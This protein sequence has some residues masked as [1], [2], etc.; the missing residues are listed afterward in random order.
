MIAHVILCNACRLQPRFAFRQELSSS[1]KLSI[2]LRYFQDRPS[3]IMRLISVKDYSLSE[4]IGRNVPPYAILSHTWGDDEV[5]FKDIQDLNAASRKEGFKKIGLCCKQAKEDGFEWVWV[6]T[7]CIDKTSSAELSEAINSMFQWYSLAMVCYTYLSDV[8]ISYYDKPDDFDLGTL[9]NSRWFTRGWTLQELIAPLTVQFFC[10]NWSYIGSKQQLA[11][12]L[13]EITSIP[14]EILD[15]SKSPLRQTVYERMHW[16]S[17]RQTTREED[18]AYCL[19]GLFDVNLP[20]LYGEGKKAFHRLQEEIIKQSDDH[21]IFLSDL[22]PT[23]RLPGGGRI[24]V[25]RTDFYAGLLADSPH[26]FGS[27]CIVEKAYHPTTR[28][29]IQISRKGSQM[30]LY[31]KKVTPRTIASWLSYVFM[32]QPEF[33]LAALNCIIL[34]DEYIAEPSFDRA[35]DDFAK[36]VAMLLVRHRDGS[37]ERVVSYYEI[38]SSQEVRHW[39]YS[40]CYIRDPVIMWSNPDD[41]SEGLADDH[42]LNLRWSGPTFGHSI[43][44]EFPDRNFSVFLLAQNAISPYG[45]FIVILCCTDPEQQ[46]ALVSIWHGD[47]PDI[48]KPDLKRIATNFRVKYPMHLVKAGTGPVLEQVFRIK[49]K[50]LVCTLSKEDTFKGPSAFE[51]RNVYTLWLSFRLPKNKLITEAIL[52]AVSEQY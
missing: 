42:E 31:L 36:C 40:T 1:T 29:P 32:E 43:I 23:K 46:K 11:P 49:D 12:L 15:H 5:S 10:S 27:K 34:N 7:C 41:D 37:Y 25:N 3:F 39:K 2:K 14:V 35:Q 17:R 52:K 21:T 48:P 6:D 51:S 24:P 18:M 22:H 47:Q 33:Y 4:F 19:F 8:S 9:R 16:A 20:L 13:S 26:H 45:R 50:E 44:E 30:K 38:V 28:E